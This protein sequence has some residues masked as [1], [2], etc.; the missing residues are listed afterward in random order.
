MFMTIKIQQI[1]N[2]K[3]YI[4]NTYFVSELYYKLTQFSS[5]LKFVKDLF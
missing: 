4:F 1:G 5:L 3:K 2:I